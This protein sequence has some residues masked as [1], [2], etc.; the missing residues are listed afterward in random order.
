MAFESGIRPFECHPTG[1][2]SSVPLKMHYAAQFLCSTY[3]RI[4]I[5][6]EPFLVT[7]AAIFKSMWSLLLAYSCSGNVVIVSSATSHTRRELAFGDQNVYL[8]QR[9]YRLFVKKNKTTANKILVY[10]HLRWLITPAKQFACYL[11]YL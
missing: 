7:L 3:Y 1:Y 10:W 6:I 4:L 2:G 11:D 5:Q 9:L 8:R